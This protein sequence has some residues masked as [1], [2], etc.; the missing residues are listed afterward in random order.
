MVHFTSLIVTLLV[1]HASFG[2]HHTA[3]AAAT[4]DASIHNKNEGTTSNLRSRS[5]SYRERK[6]KKKEGS[7]KG[8][9]LDGETAEPDGTTPPVDFD[10]FLNEHGF[11][12]G[13]T[14]DVYL[15]DTNNS[16]HLNDKIYSLDKGLLEEQEMTPADAGVQKFTSQQYD[17]ESITVTKD[18]EGNIKSV[19]LMTSNDNG[20]PVKLHLVA[21][22]N[23]VMVKLNPE[24]E[25]IDNGMDL[26]VDDWFW[27]DDYC[28]LCRHS[29]CYGGH[30]YAGPGFYYSM[31]WQI[32]NDE[33]TRVLIPRGQWFLYY[34][35]GNLGGFSGWH[36]SANHGI[37]LN[38]GGHNDLVSSF[39]IGTW[40]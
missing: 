10:V 30:V 1:G 24:K 6:T 37:N 16:I 23:K 34:E 3:T 17:N 22:D 4:T 18:M 2:Y 40:N 28:C 38:M 29:S 9:V 25:S 11:E 5:L 36:G 31:P 20:K 21:F 8:K 13:S 19:D 27:S 15:L 7:D 12:K 35:H 33:L 32:G 39:V 26:L 14:V